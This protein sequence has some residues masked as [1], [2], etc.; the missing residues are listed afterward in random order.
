[1]NKLS[2]WSRKLKLYSQIF[3]VYIMFFFRGNSWMTVLLSLFFTIRMKVSC[4]NALVIWTK[5]C[6]EPCDV[7]CIDVFNIIH[8]SR[9]N[10][11]VSMADLQC[12]VYS[13][14][15]IRCWMRLEWMFID[16][17]QFNMKSQN[18]SQRENFM[19]HSQLNAPL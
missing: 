16:H 3:V 19:K 17:F 5:S 8:V 6:T 7:N 14:Q 13:Y 1:M 10:R 15:Q 9:T 18:L 12:A 4:K 11:L 2:K